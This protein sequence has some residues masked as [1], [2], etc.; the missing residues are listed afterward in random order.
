MNEPRRPPRT[1]SAPKLCSRISG[2]CRQSIAQRRDT[3]ARALDAQ[4]TTIPLRETHGRSDEKLDDTLDGGGLPLDV[5]NDLIENVIGTYSLPLGVALN[6]AINGRDHLVPMCIEEPSVVAAASNAAKMVR[7]GGG[8]LAEMDPP[9]MIAQVELR[10]VPAPHE[11]A[12]AIQRATPELLQLADR[13]HPKL[14]ARGGG[15]RAIEPR[16][17]PL[18]PALGADGPQLVVVHIHVDCRDA[19]GANLV[20]TVAERLAP[21]LAQLANGQVGL[22]I[23]SNLADQRCVRV[24]VRA[25]LWALAGGEEPSGRAAADGLEI[26][27]A[28]VAASRFA[29][30]DPYRAATHNKGIMNGADAVA[31]ACGQDWRSL[32]AGAHAYAARDGGYRPLATWRLDG[33]EALVG[34]LE[35]PMAVGTV[36]GALR[37][38][39]GAA[40]ALRLLGVESAATLGAAI[41]SAGLATNLAALK[42]LAT[43]GIQRGHMSLHARSVAR[44]VG[45]R[46]DWVERVADELA[47]EGDVKPD[48]ARAIVARL[49][50]GGMPASAVGGGR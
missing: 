28:I 9:I 8:F 6:F 39:A 44:A 23:L 26:A 12:R 10:D 33:D 24:R 18:D 27:S 25:P 41:A 29:E 22:R 48:R 45:A 37:V 46:G 20:N 14:V 47:Q 13:A 32:E 4:G 35:L 3:I 15:A 7:A 5:A 40:L 19:M 42:A 21:R 30:V 1:T 43:E 50:A 2:F 31:L 17:L 36:G 38:H 49:L 34:A 16:L 11:A